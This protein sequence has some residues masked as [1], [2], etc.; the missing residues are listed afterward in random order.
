MWLGIGETLK[1]V[2]L[3]L[4][5]VVY[6]IPMTRDAML[7]VPRHTFIL[8]KDLGA[9]DAEAIRLGVLP[10][11]MPRIWDAITVAV[12]IMWTYITVA[13]YVNAQTGLGSMISNSKRFSAMDQVFAGIIVIVL[14]ALFDQPDARVPQGPSVPLGDRMSLIEL[15]GVSQSYPDTDGGEGMVQIVGDIDLSIE[16][17][18]L[19]MLLG[20]S[21]CGKSTLLKHDGRGPS[22]QRQD[23]DDRHHHDRWAAR[24]RAHDD[25]VMVF[26]HY[27]NLPHLIG[28]RQRRAS[29]PAGAVVEGRQAEQD[30]RIQWALD[31]VGL[32]HRA[33]N[34]P[35]QL[36]GAAES[37]G[38]HRPCAGAQAQDPVDGRALRRA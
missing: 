24:P 8:M 36:S 19:N 16:A 6:L 3:V 15:S 30:A 29:V 18:S 5:A 10:M 32:A 23:A 11:A 12:S 27:S 7:A 26:Q 35:A 31:R 4:G 37:A 1:V 34:R 20:P 22:V 25:T 13:E 14:L 28:S 33:D 21:G 2:F 38:G 9:S 17:G